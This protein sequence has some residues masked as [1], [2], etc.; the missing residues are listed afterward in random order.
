MVMPNIKLINTLFPESS[1][2]ITTP[3]NYYNS[4]MN[5]EVDTPR[6]RSVSSS[7]NI[8]REL[9]AHSIISFIP[10]IEMMKAQSNNLLS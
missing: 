9:L 10:Y 2:I 5:I 7:A 8:S 4:N 1:N 6:E 3:I